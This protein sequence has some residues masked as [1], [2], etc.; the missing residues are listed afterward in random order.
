VQG[1]LAILFDRL[2]PYHVARIAAARALYPIIAIEFGAQTSVYAWERV[3][4]AGRF[5]R[6]A[7][8][9]DGLP[10]H[11]SSARF[12]YELW[13]ILDQTR[14][15][16]LAVPGWAHRGCLV[17]IAWA[18]LHGA[19]VI[20]MSDSQRDDFARTG[21]RE[22][23]KKAVVY[24]CR[25]GFVGGERHAEY[26]R[27]LGM[28]A[29]L[30]VEG[31]DVVDNEHFAR[32]ASAARAEAASLR[33]LLDLPARYF[34][35]SARFL[36][37]KNLDGLLRAFAAYRGRN[38]EPVHLVVLGDGPLKPELLALVD[39]L[40]L[41]P[42]V[43]FPG[44]RQYDELPRYYALAEAFVHASSTEQ[45]GLVVNEAMAAGL[46]VLV[47]R[48][49]GCAPELVLEGENGHTFAPDDQQR[50]ACLLAELS[51]SPED[52]ARMGHR[53]TEI[54]RGFSPQTFALQLG[55]AAELARRRS[56][57]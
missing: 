33:A 18:R 35:S 3:D 17:A 31:Y 40:Q 6:H 28:P 10:E 14:P 49:C 23:V 36:P 38:T 1:P 42:Y 55:R 12:A 7:V 37:K 50:L 20:M 19:P 51:A 4:A 43:H 46:P 13:S 48:S 53:S 15:S 9:R 39:E 21:W 5:E 30:I 52:R 32:G 29:E 54:I 57:V 22:A 24:T 27:E 25:A 56:A 8:I 16:V 45:W 34:L 44:F 41:Q 26:L 11:A 2:G 47:S